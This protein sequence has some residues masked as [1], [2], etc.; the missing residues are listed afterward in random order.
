MVAIYTIF[1]AQEKVGSNH[2]Y[3]TPLP[4]PQRGSVFVFLLFVFIRETISIKALFL[5]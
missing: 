5:L 1:N 2:A 3:A 4:P